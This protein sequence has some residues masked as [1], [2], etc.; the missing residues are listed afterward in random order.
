MRC[1]PNFSPNMP[2][3]KAAREAAQMTG[4]PR[5]DLYARILAR[6]ETGD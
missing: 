6:K 2:A 5:A 1:S 3:G 4:L